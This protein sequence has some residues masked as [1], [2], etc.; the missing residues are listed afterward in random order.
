MTKTAGFAGLRVLSLESRRAS[1]IAR[2]IQNNGGQAIVVPSTRDVPVGA[3]PEITEFISQLLQGKLN[4]VI[5][6]TGVGTRALA[7]AA[8]NVCPK[9]EFVAALG[10]IA[11]IARG[12]KPVAAL[13]ELGVP[14][15]LTIPEPNTWREILQTL[16]ANQEKVPLP[17]Q[18]IAIQEYGVPSKELQ[19]GLFER[20]AKVFPVHV[21]EWALPEDITPLKNAVTAIIEKE[22]A[23]VLFTSSIQIHH[24]M[25]IAEEVNERARTVSSLNEIVVAS[26]GPTTSET[27][28]NYGIAVDMEP[29][30]SKMGFL[31]KEAADQSEELLRK[32]SER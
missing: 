5:F 7:Q 18:N 25:Q 20:G 6:L 8:E 31:V 17:G 28:K 32:K 3:T 14:I 15:T 21:Y 12:P 16:D 4:A 26:I 10:R 11:V 22:V 2:L 23:L 1:E 27:L 24:L 19:E 9:D 13:K 29:S 30:H